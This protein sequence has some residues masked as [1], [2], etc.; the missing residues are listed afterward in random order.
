MLE[1]ITVKTTC[2]STDK[3]NSR[4]SPF[5]YMG[6]KNCHFWFTAPLSLENG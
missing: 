4:K 6:I 2:L 3:K 1:T 5:F